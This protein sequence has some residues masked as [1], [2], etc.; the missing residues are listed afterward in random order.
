MQMLSF[1]FKFVHAKGGLISE[2]FLMLFRLP[3]KMPNQT[4]EQIKL[5]TEKSRKLEFSDQGRGFAP[6]DGNGTKVKIP[7]EIKP[8]FKGS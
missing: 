6:F 5:F 3:K 7:S 2:G 1:I 4:L 8:T